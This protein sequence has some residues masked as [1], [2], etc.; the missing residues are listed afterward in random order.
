MALKRNGTALS[1]DSH[2]VTLRVELPGPIQNLLRLRPHP[3]HQSFPK[4]TCEVEGICSE[5]GLKPLA[6]PEFAGAN[7]EPAG[8]CCD[9]TRTDSRPTFHS[10]ACGIATRLTCL[11]AYGEDRARSVTDYFVSGGNWQMSAGAGETAW[12]VDA[13]ND[14]VG[15]AM[16]CDFQDLVGGGTL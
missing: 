5:R 13:E 8:V 7:S 11:L 15:A 12:F 4:R 2:Q 16:L 9:R 3:A 1:T 14:Q 10:C 6:H